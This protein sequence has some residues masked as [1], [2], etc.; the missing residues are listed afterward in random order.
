MGRLIGGGRHAL[1][2]TLAAAW[3]AV[4]VLAADQ[5]LPRSS[6]N[7]PRSFPE[8]GITLLDEWVADLDL[9]RDGKWLAY[10]R[11]DPQDWYMDIWAVRLSGA[12]RR[13]LTCG[14]TVPTKHRGS[15]AWH[16]AGQFLAFSA[17]NDDVRTRKGD[18]LAEPGIGLN[19][20]LWV[21]TADGAHAWRLTNYETDYANPRGVIHPH[22][23]PDGKRLGWSG[24][25]DASKV[26]PGFEWGEWAVFLADFE[27]RAGVPTVK[28][29]RALQPGEQHSY[30]QLDDWSADG[31]RVLVSANP[32]PGQSVSGQDIYELEI[33]TGAF[34]ALTRTNGEWD[35]YAH[36]SPG[37]RQ[38]LW[39]SSRGLN[40]KFH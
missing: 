30:Y 3:V 1:A 5:R 34:R 33:K 21:M 26:A 8:N 28:N 17:E 32:R 11:R 24:L 36:Y 13:C 9:S 35:Q 12:D 2:V 40:V 23:S 29:I 22:F 27:V 14:L 15:V 4:A 39:A 38:V 7:Y 20:N 19:T 16:P 18:R 10:P 25:V 6:A 31:K 37:G